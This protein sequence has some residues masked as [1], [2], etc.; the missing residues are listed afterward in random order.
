MSTEHITITPKPGQTVPFRNHTAFCVGT[1]RMGLALQQA[2]QEQL[3]AVQALCRFRHIRGHGL[4]HDDMAIYQPYT[5]ETGT[6]R[7]RYN[8]TYLD[9]VMDSYVANG[10]EPFLELG[11]MPEQLAGSD[12]TLFYWKAH[13]VPPKDENAWCQLVQATLRH[14]LS[15]Y[16]ERVTAWPIE[17]WNEP[18]LHGFWENADK[19]AYLRLYEITSRAVKEV[20]PAFQV[21]GPAICGGE[22]SQAWVRDFLA[23]CEEKNLPVDFVT[24]HA[25][26]GQQPEHRGKYLYHT[27][28]PVDA[29][30]RELQTTRDIID[31]FPRF[32]GIPLHITE[33]NTS[34]N[35]FCPI[36][37]TVYNAA[38]MAQLLSRIGDVADSYS[39]WTFGDVFEEQGVPATPF[40]GGFGLM[41]NGLIPKPTLWAFAWFSALRGTCVHR[42]DHCLL[43]RGEGGSYEGIAWNGNPEHPAPLTLTLSLP[44]EEGAWVCVRERV[45]TGVGDPLQVWHDLGEPDTL[46]GEQLHLL[47]QAAHPAVT[48]ARLTPVTGALALTLPLSPCEVTHFTLRPAP[49]TPDF[50]YDYAWYDH[51]P[52]A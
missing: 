8:F 42:D 27:M 5:D 31:S 17:V 11:F 2:Y 47:R 12:H 7:V 40:H 14:L 33:F 13:T 9:Q 10:L 46:T 43:L 44:G 25:Y 20:S 48:T 32:R 4:F 45:A 35:P 1:G 51:F 6:P 28:C 36:H 49:H 38:V 37:D 24:R 29:T 34:Y 22:G 50:G 41:A 23:F 26:M 19:P 18:N 16:G 52:R 3:R 30:I 15:R 21:G 39:Y